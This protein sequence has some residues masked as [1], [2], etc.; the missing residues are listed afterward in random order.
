MSTWGKT[1]TMA[2]LVSVASVYPG[3]GRAEESAP[4]PPHH[5]TIQHR[6][7]HNI[8][9]THTNT[10]THKHRHTNT[11]QT[12]GPMRQVCSNDDRNGCLD[13]WSFCLGTMFHDKAKTISVYKCCEIWAVN[14]FIC[15]VYVIF[16]SAAQLSIPKM[17][18]DWI[19]SI[20]LLESTTSTHC[21][22]A[23]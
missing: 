15:N 11:H 18:L 14:Q 4:S 12:N 5:S 6:S 10:Y 13:Q 20:Q 8:T 1:E 3:Q 2:M 16:L 9:Q 21:S 23:V 19:N 17:K 22:G 7:Q